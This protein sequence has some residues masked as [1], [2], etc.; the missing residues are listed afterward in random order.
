MKTL[1]LGK[2][3]LVNSKIWSENN[4]FFWWGWGW[5]VMEQ[6]VGRY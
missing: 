3:L 1:R 6:G 5:K 2:T 4:L